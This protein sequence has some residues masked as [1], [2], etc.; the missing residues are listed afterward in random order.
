MRFQFD[1]SS[2][3]LIEIL[4]DRGYAEHDPQPQPI[5]WERMNLPIARGLRGLIYVLWDL[6]QV[7]SREKAGCDSASPKSIL[8]K[9]VSRVMNWSSRR[10]AG[11]VTIRT[12]RSASKPERR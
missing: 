12:T 1:A 6:S 11:A 10:P 9:A 5:V 8:L 3:R 7:C 2:I 4:N